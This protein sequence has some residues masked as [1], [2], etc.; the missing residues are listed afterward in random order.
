MRRAMAALAALLVALAGITFLALESGG[1]AVVETH[2]A[3]GDTRST[4]VWYVDDDGERWLEAG[5]P[6]NGWFVDVRVDPSLTLSTAEGSARYRAHPVENPV[7]HQ[8]IRSLI[9]QKYGWRDRWVGFLIVDSSGS[10][11]VRLEPIDADVA[12]GD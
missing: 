9:R 8:R 2:G 5:T 3:H 7:V 10:I 12:A 11:P 6:D 4:H 1:V